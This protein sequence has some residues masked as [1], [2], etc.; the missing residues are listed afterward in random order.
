[1]L[2]ESR[3]VGKRDFALFTTVSAS[4]GDTL[5]S[6]FPLVFHETPNE[7]KCDGCM[8]DL[9]TVQCKCR[10]SKCEARFCS[11]ACRDR[12]WTAWH[13]EACGNDFARK[14]VQF[15][16]GRIRLNYVPMDH[17][18]RAGMG[19]F[20]MMLSL[21]AAAKRGQAELMDLLKVYENLQSPDVSVKA[22]EHEQGKAIELVWACWNSLLDN[23]D[24]DARKCL[25]S[26]ELGAYRKF[27]SF[28]VSFN[29]YNQG[30]GVYRYQSLCRHKC[31][32][33]AAVRDAG[34]EGPDTPLRLL[35]VSSVHQDEQLFTTFVNPAATRTE[36]QAI[37]KATYGIDCDCARCRTDGDIPA[38]EMAILNPG[39]AVM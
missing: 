34:C 39:C 36:R 6:E 26:Q 4:P 9:R 5:V 10:S 24:L 18:W 37:L 27:L 3:K 7:S 35:A 25:Q 17:Q 28:V 31:R 29:M 23:C 2:V 13:K 33:N 11:E 32:P 16:A 19:A 20:K 1:M 8:S 38:D 12:S 30:G 21:L 15:C 22:F 14:A